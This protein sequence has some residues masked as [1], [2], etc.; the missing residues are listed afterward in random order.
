METSTTRKPMETDT[1]RK[2]SKETNCQ[3]YNINITLSPQ[4]S[5]NKYGS[6][7]VRIPN[8]SIR[9]DFKIFQSSVNT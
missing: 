5:A 8:Q 9:N 6:I 1:M 4:R 7:Q 3:N 2:Q